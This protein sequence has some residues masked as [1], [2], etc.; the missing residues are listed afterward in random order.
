MALGNRRD[1]RALPALSLA[2]K[3]DPESLVRLHTAWALGEIG[4]EPARA[5]LEQVLA[6][7]KDPDVISEITDA[8]NLH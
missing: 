5:A 4:G 7:E 1:E 6:D 3:E 8:L 2:L